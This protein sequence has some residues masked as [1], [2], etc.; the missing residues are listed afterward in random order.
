MV[1]LIFS[2]AGMIIPLI[3]FPLFRECL[4]GTFPLLE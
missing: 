3:D 1:F 2:M 4:L